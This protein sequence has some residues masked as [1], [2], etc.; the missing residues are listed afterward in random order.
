MGISEGDHE[1]PAIVSFG[2]AVPKLDI[3][4]TV[5]GLEIPTQPRGDVVPAGD[6]I[7][8]VSILDPGRGP[9]NDRERRVQGESFR[10]RRPWAA[11]NKRVPELEDRA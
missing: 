10:W 4:V 9:V 8:A 7:F 3:I 2:V 6:G 1:M 5:G 11:A